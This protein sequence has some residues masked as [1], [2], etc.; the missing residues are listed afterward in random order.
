[1]NATNRCVL[2]C[3]AM[4]NRIRLHLLVATII[5]ARDLSV[6]R[7]IIAIPSLH[8]TVLRDTTGVYGYY[9]EM[10]VEYWLEVTRRPKSVCF[11]RVV[12]ALSYAVMVINICT[13]SHELPGLIESPVLSLSNPNECEIL[14]QSQF[15]LYNELA[16][17]DRPTRVSALFRFHSLCSKQP[18]LCPELST[19]SFT[20]HYWVDREASCACHAIKWTI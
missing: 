16:G 11:R 3:A 19:G 7:S 17:F 9:A 10:E 15:R 13:C 6:R 20:A 2:H 18:N 1:M 14:H 5:P 4:R 8:T 12:R